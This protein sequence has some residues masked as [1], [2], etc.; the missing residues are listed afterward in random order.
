MGWAVGYDVG[1][2]RDIGYGVPAVCDHPGCEKEIDR[3]LGYV[4]GGDVYGGEHGCGLFF[5]GEHSYHVRNT[6]LP[7]GEVWSPGICE[8]C[9]DGFALL[10][11]DGEYKE[12]PPEPFSPK[13]DLDN[14]N[15]HKMNCPSWQAWRDENPEF[16]V[17]HKELVDLDY[18]PEQY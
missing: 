18:D 5:C 2:Q 9:A 7:D 12:D 4:C 11:P 3:G 10:G 1:W 13:P 6:D 14:W 15:K 8:R 17:K 16:V